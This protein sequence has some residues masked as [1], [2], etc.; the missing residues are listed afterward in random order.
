VANDFQERLL[1]NIALAFD[2]AADFY[3]QH[4]GQL[5]ARGSAVT[6]RACAGRPLSASAAY[7]AEPPRPRWP[8]PGAKAIHVSVASTTV[9]RSPSART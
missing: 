9:E 3:T 8:A 6:W 7:T 5:T 1:F 2:E 4:P